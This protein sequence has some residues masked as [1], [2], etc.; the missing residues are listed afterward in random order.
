MSDFPSGVNVNGDLS[1]RA[2]RQPL[3]GSGSVRGLP[4]EIRGAQ[5]RRGKGD[6]PAVRRPDRIL[7][8]ECVRV[9]SRVN[10]RRDTS[11]IQ[12]SFS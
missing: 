2:G 3:G 6:A 11:Q 9:V 4:I 5:S 7:V 8:D 12:M 1:V 10:V